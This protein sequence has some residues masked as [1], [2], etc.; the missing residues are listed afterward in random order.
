MVF[1]RHLAQ[2]HANMCAL[3]DGLLEVTIR[4][5]RCSGWDEMEEPGGGFGFERDAADFV[6]QK[7]W[8]ASQAAEWRGRVRSV[9]GARGR[10][11]LGLAA[12]VVGG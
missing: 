2:V 8:V 5:A 10:R 7:Q 11:L 9:R 3:P 12:W 1:L 4:L 6:G